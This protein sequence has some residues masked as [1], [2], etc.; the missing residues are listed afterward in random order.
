MRTAAWLILR[1]LIVDPNVKIIIIRRGGDFHSDLL[2][3]AVESGSY[4]LELLLAQV[5]KRNLEPLFPR[6][7]QQIAENLRHERV[8]L[9]FA[10]VRNVGSCD[11]FIARIP[12]FLSGH[13]V[14]IN[15]IVLLLLTKLQTTGVLR[16]TS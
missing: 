8:V 14:N 3:R 15:L 6:Q 12:G 11:S 16:T 10:R 7:S 2:P 4:V 5:E 9:S 13:N 1:H